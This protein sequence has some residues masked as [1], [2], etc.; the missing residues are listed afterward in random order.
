M[1]AQKK[2]G[3]SEQELLA[4]AMAVEHFHTNLYGGK[5]KIFTD[6]AP[7]ARLANNKNPPSRIKRWMLSAISLNLNTSLAKATLLQTCF[8]DYQIKM[9]LEVT[10][11]TTSL[12]K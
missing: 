6:R 1:L 2:Y 5:V 11:K 4:I 7:L 8:R 3:T 9:R 10:P 12:T